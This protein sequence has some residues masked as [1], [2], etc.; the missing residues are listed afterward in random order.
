LENSNDI[1][2][3]DS[4][5]FLQKN[6]PNS[7][8]DKFILEY[9]QKNTKINQAR[10]SHVDSQPEIPIIIKNKSDE[11]NKPITSHITWKNMQ[12]LWKHFL[13]SRNLPSIIF[14]NTLKSILCKKLEEYY[15]E[16]CDSFEGICSKHLPIIQR[17]ILF[18]ENTITI[19]ENNMNWGEQTTETSDI[20]NIIDENEFEIDELCILFKYWCD[21]TGETNCSLNQKQMLDLIGH[22]Y[23]SI[24]I[25]QEKYI[26]KLGSSLWDKQLDVQLFIENYKKENVIQNTLTVHDLYK[27]YC[28]PKKVRFEDNLNN[29]NNDVCQR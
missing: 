23:P 1:I 8:V 18:W 12:Y 21:K 26:Y 2:L 5:L 14:Q 9:F 29:C 19:H 15:V 22:F 6:D 20:A 16:K 25:E 13:D 17:F 27:Y 10:G 11:S 3:R 28:K 24:E 4:V 7:I